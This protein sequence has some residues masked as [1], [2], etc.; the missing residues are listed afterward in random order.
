MAPLTFPAFALAAAAALAYTLAALGLARRLRAEGSA[1]GPAWPLLLGAG[2]AMAHLGLHVWAGNLR[3]APDL[4]F[5][6]ALSLVSLWMAA[7]TVAA[8]RLERLDALG[9]VVFPAAAVGVIAYALTGQPASTGGGGTLAWPILMHAWLALLAY[10]ALALGALFAAGLWLQERALRQ[11]RITGLVRVLPPITQS[12]SLLFRTLVA[13]SALLTLALATGLVF[14]E[15]L[16]AQHLAHKT[17]LSLLSW[18]VLATLLFGH[19]RWGWRGAQAA[20]WTLAA[21]ALLLLAFF[22]SGFAYEFLLAR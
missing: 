12:E 19:W 16:F 5:F 2:G 6:A 15:D 18:A 14:V 9:V 4:H 10:A 1:H 3:G 11:R 20:R 7:L 13:A 8:A 22:G 17:V 21:M